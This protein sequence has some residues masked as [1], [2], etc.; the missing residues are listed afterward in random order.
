M[1]LAP[2]RNASIRR[3]RELRLST[4]LR[5]ERC[6]SPLQA[7]EDGPP[8]EVDDVA[9]ATDRV[10]LAP[11]GRTLIAVRDDRAAFVGFEKSTT[12]EWALST[13]LEFSGS[14]SPPSWQAPPAHR[15]FIRQSH[16]LFLRREH[17][18]TTRRVARCA[19]RAIQRLQG[20][21]GFRGSG[22][23]PA[24]WHALLPSRR[25]RRSRRFRGGVTP[26]G[27]CTAGPRHTPAQHRPIRTAPACL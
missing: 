5:H 16:A 1:K 21:R 27:R 9:L 12:N 24:P 11:T 18:F 22:A 19:G 8:I 2:S 26:P 13:R 7:H 20:Y 15:D 14:T 25:H 10:E 17:E 6:R 23:E 4:A 3:V